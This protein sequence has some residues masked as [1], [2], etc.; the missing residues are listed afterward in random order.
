MTRFQTGSEA[1]VGV[2]QIA[3]LILSL[4]VLGALAADTLC[5]LPPEV[6][7]VLQA[8]DTAVCAIL[9]VDFCVR[10]YRAE[11]KLAFMRWGWIDLLASIPNLDV[12]RWGQHVQESRMKLSPRRLFAIGLAA[13]CIPPARFSMGSARAWASM[14]PSGR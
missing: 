14:P 10:F 12:L 2:F 9:L 3:I 1:K 8:V 5:D 13:A 6:R 11:S 4:V 7:A